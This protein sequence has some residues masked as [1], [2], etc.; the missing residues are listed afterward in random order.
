[1]LGWILYWLVEIVA[2]VTYVSCVREGERGFRRL[3]AFFLGFPYTFVS[4]LVIKPKKKRLTA[5]KTDGPYRAQLE[6][7][8]ERDLLLE[9]RRDRARRIA[10]SHE[11]GGRVVDEEA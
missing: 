6:L 8:E 5:P 7:E 3:A 2:N 11:G 1:M 10:Q 9:V 4:Y